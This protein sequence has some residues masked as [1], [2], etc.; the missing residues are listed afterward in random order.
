MPRRDGTRPLGDGPAPISRECR[1]VGRPPRER[2]VAGLPPVGLFKPAGT[3]ARVLK[4]VTISVDEFEAMRLVD[5]S[6]LSHEEAAAA[7]R[8]SRQTVGRMLE[9]S[10]AKV[11]Q[12]FSEGCAI[13]IEGGVFRL[14]SRP[15]EAS[16]QRGFGR[17][18]RSRAESG[19]TCP[20]K[21]IESDE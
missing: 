13:A 17:H 15:R 3:P 7:M 2:C 5:G 9:A 14:E 11:I 12:A 6:G 20:N 10:R 1:R 4:R 19:C 16:C 21:E 18:R 8:I